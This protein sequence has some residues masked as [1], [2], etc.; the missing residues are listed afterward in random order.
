MDRKGVA[1]IHKGQGSEIWRRILLDVGLFH[2]LALRD[3]AAKRYVALP[4]ILNDGIV[5]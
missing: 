4:S 2:Q 5:I 3:K 1:E